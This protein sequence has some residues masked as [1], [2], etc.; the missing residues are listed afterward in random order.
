VKE[1][2]ERTDSAGNQIYTTKTGEVI[3]QNETL[4]TERN[5]REVEIIPDP[6]SNLIIAEMCFPKDQLM[7]MLNAACVT[8]DQVEEMIE[9]HDMT[10]C[11]ESLIGDID[12]EDK[13]TDVLSA[14]DIEDYME[15]STFTDSVLESLDYRDIASNVKEY[16][17]E[18][19][20][21]S[22]ASSLLTSFNYEAPCYTGQLYIK[23]VESIIEGYMKKQTEVVVQ[24]TV[25]VD[26]VVRLRAFTIQEI[27]E[28]LDALQYTEY[29]KS[30][31]LTSLSLK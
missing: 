26:D 28:V 24:P 11:V 18:P 7:E 3:M 17:E 21:E 13:V 1:F 10:D 30:R 16:I 25:I 27:N 31:I 5:I 15:M 14:I 12:W 29:N 8:K 19:D 4:T 6:K 9:E 22:M 2:L 20:A 23:S